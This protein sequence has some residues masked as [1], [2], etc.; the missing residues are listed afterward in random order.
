MLFRSGINVGALLKD[1][2]NLDTLEGKGNVTLDV[3][4]QGATVTAMKKALNGNAA[5]KLA[6]GAI[7][8]IDIAGA[9]RNAKAKLG[10]L[11]GTKTQGANAAEKT[12]FSEMS[13]TFNI[14]NGVAHNNDLTGKSPLLRIGGE[15]DVDIGNENLN[16]VVKAT[17]VATTAGQGGKELGDLRGITVPVKLSGPFSAPQYG[18]DFSGMLS[19]AAKAVV[20]NKVEDVKAKVQEQVGDRLKGLFGR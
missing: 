13:A 12:D 20:G 3:N 10:S 7:K 5:I 17:V 4:A 6:D 2:A 8:G 1:A 9:I 18:I 11:T 16:Y 14:K 19:G 15:G